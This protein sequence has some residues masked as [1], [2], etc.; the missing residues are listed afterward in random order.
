MYP[1]PRTAKS[2][3]GKARDSSESRSQE[4][5]SLY[6]YVVSGTGHRGRG[7]EQDVHGGGSIETR[8]E[9][10][11]RALRYGSEI[12]RGRAGPNEA[13]QRKSEKD[14]EGSSKLG[15]GTSRPFVR[16]KPKS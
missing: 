7:S 1:D 16:T 11:D 10:K 3:I 5:G 14:Q 6:R 13:V 9:G 8:F 15:G 4:K 12:V 2:M